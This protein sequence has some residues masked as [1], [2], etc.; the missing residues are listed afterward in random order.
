MKKTLIVTILVL[1]GCAPE[2]KSAT[3]RDKFRNN[4]IDRTYDNRLPS[5][6][7]LLRLRVELNAIRHTDKNGKESYYLSLDFAD[8]DL[9]FTGEDDSLI[10]I[11]G[12]K[13][14][15]YSGDQKFAG[16]YY[17]MFGAQYYTETTYYKVHERMINK[18]STTEERVKV[19]IKG[20]ESSLEYHLSDLNKLNFT[21]FMWKL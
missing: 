13:R 18:I 20:R 1:I 21:K 7:T 6:G 12:E 8:E 14:Y 10:L 17:R 9:L 19:I 3:F 16:F 11:I 5:T 15:A 4:T 2:Y